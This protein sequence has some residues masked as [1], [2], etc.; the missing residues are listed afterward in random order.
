MAFLMVTA[1]ITNSKNSF[2]SL[3]VGCVPQQRNAADAVRISKAA[4]AAM[5]HGL[6]RYC[7]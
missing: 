1:A 3:V 6:I 7:C 4:I 5:L 2:E